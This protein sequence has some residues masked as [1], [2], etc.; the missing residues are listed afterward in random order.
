M[1]GIQIMNNN[2]KTKP[3]LCSYYHD[4]ATWSVEIM[5]Y[6]WDDARARVAKLGFLRL[7]GE[8]MATIPVR[9]GCL[10]KLWCRVANWFQ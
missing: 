1:W 8:L 5:A 3:F 4:R 10:A 6:D 9:V 7:D 2:S